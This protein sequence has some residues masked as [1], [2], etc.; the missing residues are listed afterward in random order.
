[1]CLRF[2]LMENQCAARWGVSLPLGVD[3]S[4]LGN[5]QG[6]VV[7]SIQ[8]VSA[9]QRSALQIYTLTCC[10]QTLHLNKPFAEQGL[11]GFASQCNNSTLNTH[12]ILIPSRSEKNIWRKMS[13]QQNLTVYRFSFEAILQNIKVFHEIVHKYS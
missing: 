12:S 2:V 7:E 13:F 9:L 4:A 10:A 11:L 1:M 8:P 5:C 6:T 3:Q